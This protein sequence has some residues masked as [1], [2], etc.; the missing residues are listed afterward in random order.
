MTILGLMMISEICIILFEDLLILV[1]QPSNSSG[2]GRL[3]LGLCE[4]G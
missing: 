4:T 1:S 2:D 3:T